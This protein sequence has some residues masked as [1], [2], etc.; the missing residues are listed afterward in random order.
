MCIF[1]I[2]ALKDWVEF[3]E[4]QSLSHRSASMLTSVASW[5]LTC[6][7]D[8]GCIQ[9]LLPLILDGIISCELIIITSWFLQ[10]WKRT[11][12]K[13]QKATLKPAQVAA[14]CQLLLQVP[15]FSVVLHRAPAT[16]NALKSEVKSCFFGNEGGKSYP[17]SLS[18]HS[19]TAAAGSLVLDG[20]VVK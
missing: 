3:F 15:H 11:W 10:N 12:W 13:S 9:L 19:L 18:E 5:V 6:R 8:L 7:N 16:T 4:H 2:Y 17:S 14:D 20:M 1:H